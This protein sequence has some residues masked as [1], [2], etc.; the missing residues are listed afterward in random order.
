LPAKLSQ[1]CTW[2]VRKKSLSDSSQE[3]LDGLNAWKKKLKKIE[4]HEKI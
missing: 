3:V 2:S 1:K 4:K